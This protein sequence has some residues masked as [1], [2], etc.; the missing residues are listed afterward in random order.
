MSS[1]RH[2]GRKLKQARRQVRES[3]MLFTGHGGLSDLDYGKY[4]IRLPVTCALEALPCE[5]CRS[6]ISFCQRSQ[7]A[8]SLQ[9]EALKLWLEGLVFVSRRTRRYR[10]SREVAAYPWK[11]ADYNR[12][13]DFFGGLLLEA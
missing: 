9:A 7:M 13:A 10:R 1:L 4:F 3:K 5:P 6:G 12:R 2:V 8:T 11:N